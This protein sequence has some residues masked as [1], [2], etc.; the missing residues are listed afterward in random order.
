M[1]FAPQSSREIFALTISTLKLFL[2][3]GSNEEPKKE[4]KIS[5]LVTLNLPKFPLGGTHIS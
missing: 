4:F 1:I 2:G 5:Q 3:F